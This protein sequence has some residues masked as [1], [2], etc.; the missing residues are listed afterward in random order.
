MERELTAR[1]DALFDGIVALKE[2]GAP[3]DA[4]R[5][6]GGMYLALRLDLAGRA[7]GGIRVSDNEGIRR[8]LLERAG[9]AVVPFQA[10]GDPEESGWFR[11]SVGAVSVQDILQG[12]RRLGQLLEGVAKRE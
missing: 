10:F 6:Q 9:L 11:L 1:Q 7:V 3:V 2:A 12:I 5:P 8:L 4:V